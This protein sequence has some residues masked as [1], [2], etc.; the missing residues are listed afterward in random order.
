LL[1][2][3]GAQKGASYFTS[4]KLEKDLEYL[5]P[6][7]RPRDLSGKRFSKEPQGAQN[8]LVLPED[9][10]FFVKC[11]KATAAF[12]EVCPDA[13]HAGGNLGAFPIILVLQV[14]KMQVMGL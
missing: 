13:A 8:G 4:Q 9:T 10:G 5:R 6:L 12:I 11:S 7:H 14:C 3:L 2:T 1:K